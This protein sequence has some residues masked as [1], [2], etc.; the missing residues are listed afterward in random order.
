MLRRL[1]AH[2]LTRGMDIDD[3][4]TT[5]LRTEIIKS[6][7]FLRKIYDEWY[8]KISSNLPEIPGAV[9]E[10]GSGAGFLGDYIPGLITSEVFPCR[11]IA[12]IL[13]GCAL[14][15]RDGS[16]RALV[17]VD[18]LHHIP[19][20]REFF[21]EAQRCL[22]PGGRILLVEPWVSAW[23]K[24]IYQ[25]LHHEPFRPDSDDWSFPSEGPLS[26][27]NGALPWIVFARD[28]PQFEREFPDLQIRLIDPWLPF[29]YLV[30][31]GVA[32]RA[33]MPTFTYP[34]W[35]LVEAGLKPWP[36]V[37]SMFAFV[38]IE[39]SHS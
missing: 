38:N 30:S 7:T 29:R 25:S 35:Q 4:R 6:K 27:A 24:L 39:R 26:G 28:R 32:L 21:T 19:A 8:R 37:W 17:L 20:V 31:G 36:N 18:V 9:L 23:S 5:D 12:V 16:L 22:A 2:P 14:P 10:L 15:F 3:P 11:N 13:D 1:L 33:I 34:I